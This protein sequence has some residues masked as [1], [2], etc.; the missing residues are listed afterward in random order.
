MA[1]NTHRF[2]VKSAFPFGVG[3]MQ[4]RQLVQDENDIVNPIHCV[5]WLRGSPTHGG[6]PLAESGITPDRII[7]PGVLQM[8][9]DVSM[10][11]PELPQILVAFTRPAQSMRKQ[12]DGIRPLSVG[13][14]V[15]LHRHNAIARSIPPFHP[16]DLDSMGGRGGAPRHRV[17]G[18][19]R[20][21]GCQAEDWQQQS[22]PDSLH[23]SM[24]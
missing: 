1:G 17:G 9:R 22:K 5:L 3:C 18:K 13:G 6:H 24:G 23:F 2:Q 21:L 12:N 16:S 10:R 14:R 20:Q 15:K 19:T 8:H 7:A 4:R 11:S